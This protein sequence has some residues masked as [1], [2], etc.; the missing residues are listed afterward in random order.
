MFNKDF[1]PTPLGVIVHMMI[2]YSVKGKVILEPS[3]GNGNI[4]DYLKSVTAKEV[5]ACEVN[6]DL[7]LILSNKCRLIGDDFLKLEAHE[8]S[9]I[10]MIVMNPPFSADERHIIHAFEIA[11]EG[12][13]IISLCNTQTLENNHYSYRRQLAAIVR[14]HG[15]SEDLG[16]CFSD[17]ERKTGVDVSVVRLTKPGRPKENEF[18]GFFL[19][20]EEEGQENGIMSYNVVR[21]L[22]NR[23]VAAI[24]IFDEQ[25]EVGKRMTAL[26]SGFYS[27]KIGFQCTKEGE[28]TQRAEF[29]KDLQKSGWKFVFDKMNMQKYTTEGLKAEIN[30][31]VE[32]QQS[33]PFTMKNIY[34]MIEMVVATHGQRMDRALLEVFDKLTQHYDENRFNVEGWKTNSHYLINQK[35]IIP[36]MTEMRHRGGM[37]IKH[38]SN[39]EKIDD[40]QKALCYITGTRIEETETL[41]AFFHRDTVYDWNTWYDWG[42]FEMKGF[43]KGTMHFKFKSE[44]VWAKFNQHVSRLKG[45][46]LYEHKSSA[47]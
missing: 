3:A 2:G 6:L 45:F 43:K 15:Y 47:A 21:D 36:Y 30:N 9:H 16:D 29:K 46:P 44:H 25:L 19:D 17:A 41:W 39:A 8:I 24:K 40:L 38:N 18:E 7:R 22:V 37:I 42:F 5:V 13:I 26:T 35:F 27:S 14:D 4:V 31:F 23:Y 32:K 1:Y 10:D 33:I 12:C 28:V 11:P 20:E 34:R